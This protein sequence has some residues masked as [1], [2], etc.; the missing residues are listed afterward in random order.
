MDLR[1][2][3]QSTLGNAYTVDREL[4]GGGMSRVFLAHETALGRNV[5]VK[6]L[7]GNVVADL[8]A[9]RFA[10]E[11]RLAASLQH[12]NIV[13][14][15]TTGVADGIPYY[16]MPYVKG[17]SLRVRMAEDGA[18]PHRLAVSILRDLARAL[19]YAHNEG[20]VHRDIKPENILLSGDAAVVTDFGIA[21]AISAAR[22]TATDPHGDMTL[23]Q[24]GSSL[25]TPAYM[26]PEQAAGDT[27]DHR[28][29]IYAWGI[30]GYELLAGE[31][32]FAGKTSLAQILAAQLSEIPVPLT[33]KAPGVPPLLA[34]L[35][36]RCLSKSP[37]QRPSSAGELLESLDNTSGSRETAP[38]LPVK[39]KLNRK[40]TAG[41]GI[42][43]LIAL[44]AYWYLSGR[45][46]RNVDPST[47][48]VAVLPFADDHADSTEAYFGEGIADELMTA[49]GK[50]P[51]LRVASR[52]SSIAV[53]RRRDLDVREIG[54]QL[55]VSTV[56]EGT[57]RRVGGQLRVTAQLTSASDGLTMWSD[58]YERESKDVFA[59]QQDITQAILAALR[60]ELVGTSSAHRTAAGPGTS[61]PEAYDLYLRG[62]Y[63]IE[64][65]GPGVRRAADYFTQATRKDPK[66]A[67]A[68]AQLAAAL[69]FFPY[70]AGVPASQAELPA[71]AAAEQALRLDS[72]LAEPR[73]ALAM[74]HW[75]A[76]R[77]KEAE[78]EFR[79]A[80]NADSTS[81]V[82]HTQFGRFLLTTG[83][84]YPAI[85]EF[86]TARR[87]DPLAA[88][89]SGWLSHALAYTGDYNA[90]FE[91]AKRSRELDPDLWNN[92]TLPAFDLIAAGRFDE[93]REVIGNDPPPPVFDGMTAWSLEKVG[94]KTRAAAIRRSLDADTRWLVHAARVHAYL[95][96]D[97][98]AKVLDE[99]EAALAKGEIIAQ[100]IPFLDRLYD[101]VRRSPRFAAIV[102]KAGLE[103]RGFTGP[104]GGRPAP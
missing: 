13:P 16:T 50:V 70:F 34:D 40:I 104:N 18:L 86:R 65:R 87:L 39:R 30:I 58:V 3:L 69:S 45:A 27:I 72:T 92:R 64:R 59:V 23:T 48:S 35:I 84:I 67:R 21:K 82:A 53:A 96:T 6:V 2:R 1:D 55:G 38:L 71:R 28:S 99:M 41:A 47:S 78:E 100:M 42:L 63:L 51:G 57:V 101:P 24:A 7:S 31:H 95:A 8:S 32:P 29:D 102:R 103:G 43:A 89:S 88:T 76:Y 73:V 15:L 61:D 14:V 62:L 77:W 25:G 19:Q 52:T 10:R 90:A 9:E 33:E 22:T 17:D 85:Q 66:F 46:S 12:P 20:V 54:K 60:P 56:V 26:S 4:G 75:H 36:M 68:Y 83:R 80:L 49:L 81:A 44:G 11:V 93:A 94:N 5:V 91:E 37:D 98:T 79:R 97:D 74:A